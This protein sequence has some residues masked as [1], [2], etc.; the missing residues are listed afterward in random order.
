LPAETSIPLKAELHA[1]IVLDKY[2][3]NMKIARKLNAFWIGS[4][5]CECGGRERWSETQ[6]P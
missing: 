6:E 5:V 2:E 3:W 4:G 1:M